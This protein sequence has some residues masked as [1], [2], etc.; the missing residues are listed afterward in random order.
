M[1]GQGLCQCFRKN[2]WLRKQASQSI[3]LPSLGLSHDAWYPSSPLKTTA[4]FSSDAMLY[5]LSYPESLHTSN[6]SWCSH[7]PGSLA[8]RS[9]QRTHPSCRPA[10]PGSVPDTLVSYQTPQPGMPTAWMMLMTS[11]AM[12]VKKNAM[13]LK[14]LSVLQQRRHLLSPGWR[15]TAS[16]PSR[17]PSPSKC[18]WVLS[19]S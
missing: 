7:R 12:K 15:D 4:L 18:K 9:K 5:L 14:E 8:H 1:D 17:L 16:L 13:K 10:S 19:R 2:P 6:N 11:W 3:R